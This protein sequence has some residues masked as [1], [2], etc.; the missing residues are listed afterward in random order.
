MQRTAI[1]VEM[2]NFPRFECAAHRNIKFNATVRLPFFLQILRCAAPSNL[3]LLQILRCAAPSNLILL[4]ILR[5]AAPLNL[6][7]LQIL[8][9]AAPLNLILPIF[10]TNITVRCT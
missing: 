1:F 4:Q 10:A 6:I 8:R 3:I 5:C 7:L 9:C 2:I